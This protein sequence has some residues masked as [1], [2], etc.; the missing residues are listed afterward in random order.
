MRNIID[1]FNGEY[2]FLSNFY[3]CEV[4][5]EGL[6][7]KST[8]AAFQAAKIKCNDELET[9]ETRK[10]FTTVSASEAKHMG[11]HCELRK[12]WE[13]VK[14]NIMETIVKEKFTS[15]QDLADKLIQTGD[16]IL[17]EGTTWHDNYW[18]N[19]TCSKCKNKQGKNKLGCIL[20]KVRSE[21]QEAR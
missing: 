13:E 5:F 19:C 7:Y 6:T 16:S 20:M 21:L 8:E 2:Y 12:D 3:P 1:K 9:L 15:H 14:D 10:L 11:R 4:H 17:I 18:G